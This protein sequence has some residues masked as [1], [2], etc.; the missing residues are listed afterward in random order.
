MFRKVQVPILGI[1]E[2]MSWF[3][4]GNCG[5]EAHVFGH[6]GAKR[7][8]EEMGLEVL[9]EIPLNIDIR[10]TSDGGDPIVESMPQ[11]GAAKA[12]VQV[13]QRVW[14]QLQQQ[15]SGGGEGASDGSQ[16]Q[17]IPTVRIK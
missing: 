8:A 9:G 13:A 14:E 4:C 17:Q 6:G 1:V 2:N 16:Q 7:T 12:Y 11:S 3:V 15:G 5:T 10:E